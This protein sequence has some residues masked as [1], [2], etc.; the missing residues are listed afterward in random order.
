[1]KC[2]AFSNRS[3]CGKA[4]GYGLNGQVGRGEKKKQLRKGRTEINRRKAVEKS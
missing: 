3:S 4:V 1:M 2:E